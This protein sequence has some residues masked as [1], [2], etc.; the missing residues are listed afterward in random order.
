MRAN[1]RAALRSFCLMNKLVAAA[2]L[3]ALCASFASTAYAA[4][5]P[6]A[7]R[8]I[9]ATYSAYMNGVSIGTLVER[10]ESGRGNYRIVSESRPSGLAAL[11]QRQPLRFESRGDLTPEG[12]RPLHF[13]ARRT[14]AEPPQVTAEFKW[15][16]KELAMNNKGKAESKS[17][18]RGTQ[19]R[20][21]IM[22]QFMFMP[23]KDAKHV[24]FSMTNGR[25]LDRYRYLVTPD[26]E[27]ET[28]L[29][30]MR[31][32]H[33]VKQRDPDD[34]VTEIWLSGAHRNL[35]VKMLIVEKNGL[36]FEQVIETLQIHD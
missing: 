5:A 9:N 26:V 27:I 28:P 20:L 10:F 4:A 14:A 36:R 17:L 23:L 31:T 15:R 24:D 13:E 19:D 35:P 12:L 1:R 3:W 34:T 32:L 33:L 11:I 22:Y 29:G 16:E 8:E 21:S 7:P 18:Q 6:A 2:G 25:K 30:R